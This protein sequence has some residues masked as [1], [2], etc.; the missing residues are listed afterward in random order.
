[1]SYVDGSR[2]NIYGQ[3]FPY[4]MSLR[5]EMEIPEEI[6]QMWLNFDRLSYNYSL[7]VKLEDKLSNTKRP[8]Y[9]NKMKQ[10][11]EQMFLKEDEKNV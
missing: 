1:M 7:E 5:Y 10:P 3:L 8:L 9:M 11:G 6:H 4:Y 2:K